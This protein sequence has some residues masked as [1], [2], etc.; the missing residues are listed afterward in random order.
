MKIAFRRI[1]RQLNTLNLR[2]INGLCE[3]KI[4]IQGISLRVK[5]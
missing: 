5:H 1:G 3:S 4:A 2:E